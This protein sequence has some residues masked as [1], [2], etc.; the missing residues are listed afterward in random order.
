MS[1]PIEI[2]NLVTATFGDEANKAYGQISTVSEKGVPS[3][4]TVHIH[5]IEH[6]TQGLI[7]SCN[8]KS[9]K[10]AHLKKNPSIAG[11][12]WNPANQIQIR[13]E[14]IADLITEKDAD[15]KEMV[16]GMW[17]K[18]RPEV[19]V[20]YLL[21][22]KGMPLDTKN[23]KVDPDQHSK[24]HGLLLITPTLWDVFE[25]NPTAYRLGKRWI[26]K[27]KNEQWKWRQVS[28]LHEK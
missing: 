7:V 9:V 16:L 3:V 1:W 11:C 12:F 26:Y 22:E 4:R 15:F 25:N 17:E 6:P 18:M 14:G 20:T 8:T 24:N 10:W 13:F 27:L 21:D 2:Y 28:S 5:S 19:R 23:P